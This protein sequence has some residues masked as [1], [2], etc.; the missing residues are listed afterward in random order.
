LAKRILSSLEKQPNLN[1]P[2]KAGYTPLMLAVLA[3][4]LELV[5]MLV[6]AGCEL[7]ALAKNGGS[8]TDMALQA[9]YDEIADYLH[10]HGARSYLRE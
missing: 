10:A 6:Q 4:S 2:N 9:G 5:E 3:N 8:A 1:L 7:D